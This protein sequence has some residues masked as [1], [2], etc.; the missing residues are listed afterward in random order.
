MVAYGTQQK[1][2]APLGVGWRGHKERTASD[3][4]AIGVWGDRISSIDAAR[5]DP[6]SQLTRPDI[7]LPSKRRS[8]QRGGQLS[9][10]PLRLL[11]STHTKPRQT[12]EK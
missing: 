10:P 2:L 9:H 1:K 6:R 8:T 12:T 3:L 11:T 7:G 5:V 4:W